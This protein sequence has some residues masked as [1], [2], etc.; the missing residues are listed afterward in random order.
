MN[1]PSYGS[2][3]GS[4]FAASPRSRSS[5]MN[6]GIGRRPPWPGSIGCGP[7]CA[8]GNWIDGSRTVPC[9]SGGACGIA[10]APAAMAALTPNATARGVFIASPSP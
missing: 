9:G 10:A 6:G 3:P 5:P 1:R 2:C 8:G 4:R 7:C